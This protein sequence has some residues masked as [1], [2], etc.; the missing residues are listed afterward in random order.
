MPDSMREMRVLAGVDDLP[1]GLRYVLVIGVFDGVHRGH[2]RVIGATVDAA[3]DLG[4]VPVALTFDPHPSAVLGGSAP[5]LLCDPAERLG[6]LSRL[7]V[8]I[9][10]VQPFDRQ[11]ADQTP[12]AF[13]R[14]LAAS[15]DLSGLVM[16]PESAF[17]RDRAG[18][19]AT[20][21]GLAE[22]MGF[23]VFEVDQL[24]V[25]G[26]PIS[27]TRLREALAG[28]RLAEVRRLLGRRYAVIGEVVA[29]D[30]RGRALGYPT[31]NLRFDQPVALPI[32]GIY[33]VRVSWGGSDPLD[34]ARRADGVASLG[35]RPT[36]GGGG[37]RT[38]EVYLFDV[39]EELY[40]ERL[41]LEF[42]RRQRG[43]RRFASAEALVR[44]M[45]RDAA[46]ARRILMESAT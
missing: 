20:I 19:L 13:L 6:H 16:T 8:G 38:L 27:S 45:D 26:A 36:F 40:G 43:E 14:R 28:G 33:A 11:F 12:E 5:P 3:R 25:A 35:V 4:A 34:P 22:P 15:R 7:G 41:R 46:R 32:D 21:E 24:T 23:R 2:Q 39:D 9:A 42:V 29:G 31:A 10:V 1:A 18:A 37:A 17:G 44:Q 30:R